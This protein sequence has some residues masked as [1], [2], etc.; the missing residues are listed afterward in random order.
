MFEFV[1]CGHFN[2]EIVVWLVISE[3][4]VKSYVGVVLVKLNLCDRVQVV[5]YVYEY[6]IVVFGVFVT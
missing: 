1:V 6:G 5:V 2:G 4:T 3:V